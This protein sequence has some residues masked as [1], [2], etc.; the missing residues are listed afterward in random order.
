MLARGTCRRR[1]PTPDQGNYINGTYTLSVQ[2]YTAPPVYNYD[3][4]ANQLTNG[5]WTD[6]DSQGPHH[7]NVTQG[8]TITVNIST[9]TAAEQTLARAALGQWHDIIG[10]NFQEVTGSTGGQLNGQ[11]A[12]SDQE[13]STSPGPIAST[14]SSSQGGITTQA[15]VDI[16]TSWVNTYGTSLDSYSFQTYLHEIGHA[17]GLGHAGN[18]NG[19]ATYA[20]DAIFA[21]DSWNTSVMSYFSAT[22]NF[23]FTNQGFTE[24]FLVTPMEADIVAMQNL[25]GLSTTTRTGNTTYGFNSNAGDLFNAS[26]YSD[27]AYTI[28]DSGGTD[29][30]DYSG[31]SD[32]QLINLTP[33]SFMNVGAN[34]GNVMIARGVTIENA[35]GGSGNDAITGNAVANTLTGNGGNDIIDGGAAADT[36]AGGSGNDTYAVD[37]A[38]DVV[39]ESAGQGTDQVNASIG[40]TLGANVENLTLTG[41]AAI[42]GTGNALDNVITGNAAANVLDGAAGAD[43]LAGGAGDDTYVVDNA[44]D[45]VSENPGAGTDLVN[46]SISWVLGANLENLTLTGSAAIGGTGNGL[47]NVICGN[48]AANALDGGDGQRPTLWQCGRTTACLAAAATTSF[49]AG[50]ART[51]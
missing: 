23:Y 51:R 19:D 7:F 34:V 17:L 32:N 49:T 5:Y 42:N 20:T 3:Q 38:G 9:L 10:V 18:Y 36:M 28:F 26:V 40:Y 24:N 50:L 48:G 41:S 1:T 35:I 37:N 21:N 22:D 31:F 39:T 29:T 46:A 43:T 12:F 8:G 14:S 11:I 15:N 25:Y 33:E 6:Y 2:T 44:S 27:V 45:V 47:A 4:I 16:S 13:D 30:L